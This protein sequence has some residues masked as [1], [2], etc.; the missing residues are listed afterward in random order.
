MPYALL[1]LW[2]DGAW[3]ANVATIGAVIYDTSTKAARVM[4]QQVDEE[5]VRSWVKPS[6]CEL[7]REQIISQVELFAMV[8][9]RETFK[10]DW[11]HRRVLFFVDNESARFSA[12][13][14]GSVSPTMHDLVRLWD[15]PNKE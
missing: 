8:C 14:G 7:E 1:S 6:A 9:C 3:E 15:G 10:R 11:V 4:G 12:I 13:K 5:I 2:T